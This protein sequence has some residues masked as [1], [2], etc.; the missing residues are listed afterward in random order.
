[1]D[2][3][4][5]MHNSSF[6]GFIPLSHAWMNNSQGE[7]MNMKNSS[8]MVEVRGWDGSGLEY[9]MGTKE[10]LVFFKSECTWY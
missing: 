6:F 5:G 4:H 9:L 8:F 2:L 7:P 3:D 10:G 1:M